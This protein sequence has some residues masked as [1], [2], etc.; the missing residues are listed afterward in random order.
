MIVQCAND[1]RS[2]GQ[3]LEGDGLLFVTSILDGIEISGL[4]AIAALF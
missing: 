3:K 4:A 2:N 1:D